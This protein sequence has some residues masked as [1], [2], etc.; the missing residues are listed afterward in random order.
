MRAVHRIALVGVDTHRSSYGRSA[1]LTEYICYQPGHR[2]SLR[3]IMADI[4][5][6]TALLDALTEKQRQVIAFV[7]D[8]LT[9]KEIGRRLGIS[10]SAVN[11]RIE[12]VRA[13]LGGLSRAQ[14][15]RLYRGQSTLVIT[16]PTS[17]SLTGKPIQLQDRANGAQ[18]FA[19]EGAADLPVQAI[20]GETSALHP[21]TFTPQRIAQ[22][23]PLV[24]LGA[25]VTIAIGITALAVLVLVAAEVL[26]RLLGPSAGT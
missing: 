21:S 4:V 19:A 25:I 7:S 20:G 5:K 23:G 18:P 10:E 15:A 6:Q 2:I 22:A 12:T 3:L 8:G 13:R 9:S 26:D 24:R 11:Q 16:I 1:P 14:I 17:N